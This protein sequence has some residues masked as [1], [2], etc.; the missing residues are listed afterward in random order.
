[1]AA[2]QIRAEISAGGGELVLY[3]WS[4]PAGEMELA[5]TWVFPVEGGGWRALATAGTP[6]PDE[7]PFVAAWTAWP[8]AASS[9]PAA[10]PLAV[11]YGWSDRPEAA[12]VEV[13]WS[14]GASS[15]CAVSDRVFVAARAGEGAAALHVAEMTLLAGDGRVLAMWPEDG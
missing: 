5:L 7:R 3:R 1:M 9:V 13:A 15:H 11:A 12:A 10:G 6:L 2:V 8:A 14:D 4:Q